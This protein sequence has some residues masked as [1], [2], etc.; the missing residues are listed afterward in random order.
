MLDLTG[1]IERNQLF[2]H[3]GRICLLFPDRQVVVAP[4]QF[5]MLR[6]N[7]SVEPLLRRAM[8]VYTVKP[9]PAGT[10]LEFIYQVLGRGTAAIQRLVPGQLVD[11][12]VPLGKS[13][14]ES[15]VLVGDREAVL[16]AGG[17]GAASL[18]LL[19]ESLRRQS[20]SVRLFLGGRS[21]IDLIGL[22]D[23]AAL[24]CKVH[25][26]TNDGSRGV[27]G[28]VTEPLLRYLVDHTSE[29]HA[30]KFVVY[31]CG[32]TPMMKRVAE[33][34]EEARVLAYASLEER[35]ACGFGVCVGCVAE[36]HCG[37]SEAGEPETDFHR[38]CIEGPV[39]RCDQLVWG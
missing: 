1:R 18:Y 12:L 17:V 24:G 30:G 37:P 34:C 36:V 20:V 26:A 2:G 32:P 29:V 16:V 19:A 4:G 33:I 15:P 35:M 38:V 23:F 39:F 28:F 22:E 10:E 13:Y 9:T 11:C 8:A 25:L 7:Q 31:T 3:Y 21:A 27:A 5:G 14:D 6:P